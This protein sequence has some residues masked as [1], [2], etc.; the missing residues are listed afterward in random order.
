MTLK[1]LS[2]ITSRA[3]VAAG[4]F[5][6][7]GFAL[8]AQAEV[9]VEFTGVVAERM[10]R[11]AAIEMKRE[12]SFRKYRNEDVVWGPKTKA[13]FDR[14]YF[15]GTEW[16][17]ER[18]I[19]NIEDY[20]VPGLLKAM[21]ERG[22]KAADPSFDGSVHITVEK[23]RI[24][25]F[26]LAVIGSTRTDMKGIVRVLDASGNLVAE[27]EIWSGLVREYSVSSHYDGPN[28]AYRAQAV[29]KRVGPIMAEFTEKVLETLYPDYDAPGLVVLQRH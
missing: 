14:S 27:H 2:Q 1:T 18:L 20:S 12:E 3:L 6:S 15:S 22:I 29:H 5:L 11:I 16:G 19:P 23:M 26:P 13:V 4:C 28:Y 24:A 8:P 25:N 21:M 9:N 10:N 17:N 7:L